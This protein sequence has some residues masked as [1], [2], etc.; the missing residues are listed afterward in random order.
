MSTAVK[1]RKELIT[2]KSV[3]LIEKGRLADQ[4]IKR[5]FT[6]TGADTAKPK[7]LMAFL[8]E[9]RVFPKDHREGFPLRNLLRQLDAVGQL[10]V[11]TTA[12][13]EHKRKNKSWF[14]VKPG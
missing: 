14:F 3:R 2:M 7:D 5:W 4:F 11:I 12:R 8:V 10:S 6:M 13:F 9:H 1:P